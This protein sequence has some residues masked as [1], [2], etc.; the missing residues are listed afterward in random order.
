[1]FEFAVEEN[2]SVVD[3]HEQVEKFWACESHG[4]IDSAESTKSIE[5]K[6]ALEIL[7]STT[8]VTGGRYEVGFCGG[9][10]TRYCQITGHKLK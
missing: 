7:G 2:Q 1:M 3:L 4:F 5:D 6:R 10:K 8:K 9:V